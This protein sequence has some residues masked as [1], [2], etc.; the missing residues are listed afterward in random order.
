MRS[1]L[2]FEPHHFIRPPSRSRVYLC[3]FR[4]SKNVFGKE[5]IE[6]SYNI[7]QPWQQDV[8][9]EPLEQLDISPLALLRQKENASK[10]VND[11]LHNFLA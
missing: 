1:Q 11:K 2:S 6:Q 4:G 8:R 3:P 5:L 10:K 7:I 9:E